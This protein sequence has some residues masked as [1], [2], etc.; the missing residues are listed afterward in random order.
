MP[1]MRDPHGADGDGPIPRRR[2]RESDLW[3]LHYVKRLCSA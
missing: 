1:V 2:V 3:R